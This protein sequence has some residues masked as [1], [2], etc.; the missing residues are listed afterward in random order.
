M[1][2][3]LSLLRIVA[4]VVCSCDAGRTET[5]SVQDRRPRLAVAFWDNDG[6]YGLR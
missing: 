6:D 4:A 2:A 3:L 1:L 5:T